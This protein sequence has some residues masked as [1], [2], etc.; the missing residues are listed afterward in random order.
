[1]DS[2]ARA[3]TH[4]SFEVN[5]ISE[6]KQQRPPASFSAWGSIGSHRQ[7]NNSLRRRKKKK[8]KKDNPKGHLWPLGPVPR[9]IC[10]QRAPHVYVKWQKVCSEASLLCNKGRRFVCAWHRWLWCSDGG[11]VVSTFIRWRLDKLCC[12]HHALVLLKACFRFFVKSFY[13]IKYNFIMS[14]IGRTFMQSFFWM[15]YEKRLILQG[16]SGNG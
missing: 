6:D 12:E 3:H 16:M 15:F 8:K 14:S 1:M 7:I 5:I 2:A 11:S 13:S 10:H 4:C 9:S